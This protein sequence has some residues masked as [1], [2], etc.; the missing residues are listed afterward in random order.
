MKS[1]S[2]HASG[3]AHYGVADGNNVVDLTRRLKYPDLKALIAADA[4]AEAARAAKGATADFT[5]DQIT[6]DPAIVNP[7]KI[8]CVGLNYHEH[9]NETGM[10]KFPY[11]A[12]F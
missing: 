12:I 2:F 8:I 6:F 1:L 10:E 4:R 11:P 5:L 9:L 3:A 7:D